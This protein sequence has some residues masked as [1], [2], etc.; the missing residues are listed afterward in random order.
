MKKLLSILLIALTLSAFDAAALAA[1]APTP[2]VN[3][4]GI[5]EMWVY[6]LG[7]I[8]LHAYR[9]ND[10]IDNESFLIETADAIVGIESPAFYDNLDEY[11]GYIAALGKPM[12][13]LLLPYHPA[14]A[15]V[16]ADVSVVGT[17]EARAAQSG[18]G[19]VKGLIDGFVAAFGEDFNGNIPEISQVVDPG[20]VTLDG[21]ALVISPTSDGFDIEIPAINAVF[22]HMFGANV[23]NILTSIDQVDA[24]IAQVSRYQEKGY[25]LVLS[26]HHVPET[27]QD[28]STKLNYLQRTREI[29][30]ASNS[31]DAFTSAMNGAFPGYSGANYLEISAG[32]LY[33]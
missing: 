3:P 24:M 10:P 28:V 5:G 30:E 31:A 1:D 23:H 20:P 32:A 25:A 8:T 22:T 6:D 33:Q 19:A 15:D 7:N 18:D 26:S 16:Y 17:A 21:V 9:T 2:E 29:I 13:T 14:G 4:L 12:N 11:I 27:Q